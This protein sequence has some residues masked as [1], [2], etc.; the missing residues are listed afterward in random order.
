MGTNTKAE[1]CGR[2]SMTTAVDLG[3][4]EGHNPFDGDRIEIDE[5][6]MRMVSPHVIA[7]SRVKRQLNEFATRLT[8]GR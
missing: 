1:A 3:E 7:L 5:D 6:T 8:Y 2:C 4:G